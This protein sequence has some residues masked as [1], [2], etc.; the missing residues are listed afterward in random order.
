MIKIP[1]KKVK[2][3]QIQV[4]Q[5]ELEHYPQYLSLY[6]LQKDFLNAITALD[7]ANNLYF[8]LRS[9]IE[10]GKENC[11]IHF[12]VSQA[13]T[14]I[15][16]CLHSR[17]ERDEYTKNVMLYLNNTLDKALKNIV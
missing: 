8:L 15:K 3:S 9:K 16:C 12:T 11:N 1:L 10:N 17:F 13:A 14:I 4:L 5:T 7:I 2:I 6:S